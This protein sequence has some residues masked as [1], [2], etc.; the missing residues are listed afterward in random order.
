MIFFVGVCWSLALQR[1]DFGYAISFVAISLVSVPLA[2]YSLLGE[3]LP[4]TQ[5]FG[6]ELAFVGVTISA[7]AR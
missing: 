3:V 2:A 5:L 6:L 7:F 1:P 4:P